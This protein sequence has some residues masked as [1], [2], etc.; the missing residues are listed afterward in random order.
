MV[1]MTTIE[2]FFTTLSDNIRLLGDFPTILGGDWNCTVSRGDRFNN[3]NILNM[4]APPNKRHSEYLWALCNEF[5]M[6][7]LF[8]VL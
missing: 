5:K 4:A 3:I 8:P 6:V 1:L 2:I 7:D